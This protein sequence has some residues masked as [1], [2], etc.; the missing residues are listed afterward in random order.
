[1]RHRGFAVIVVEWIW[2]FADADLAV[3][4]EEMSSVLWSCVNND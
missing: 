2:D 4:V 3:D 1:M